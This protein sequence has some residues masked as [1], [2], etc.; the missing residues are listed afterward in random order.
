MKK[1]LLSGIGFYKRHI[2]SF[3]VTLFG[4]GCRFTPTCS[5]YAEGA[6]EKFGVKKGTVLAIKRILKCHPFG[7]FG[8]DPVPRKI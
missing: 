5:E 4:G 7:G 8:F 3:L 6:I 2:S 1:V